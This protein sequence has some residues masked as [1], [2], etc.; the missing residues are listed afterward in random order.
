MKIKS[1]RDAR[2]FQRKTVRGIVRCCR[3]EYERRVVPHERKVDHVNVQDRCFP[4]RPLVALLRCNDSISVRTR[5]NGREERQGDIYHKSINSRRF[6][7]DS[8]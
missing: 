8:T 1:A 7:G 6:P 5:S 3:R 2:S 4:V